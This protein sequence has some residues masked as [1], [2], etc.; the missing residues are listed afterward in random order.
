MA[1]TIHETDGTVDVP[2]NHDRPNGV[3]RTLHFTRYGRVTGENRPAALA[4]HG[5]PGEIPNMAGFLEKTALGRAMFD[6]WDFYLLHQRGAGK[7]LLRDESSLEYVV[8]SQDDYKLPQ[9]LADLEIFR[10]QICASKNGSWD[11]VFGSSWGGNLG[12][13]YLTK[14]PKSVHSF[15]LGSFDASKY[16]TTLTP[17]VMEAAIWDAMHT[18]P[19]LQVLLAKVINLC[20]R[21]AL[22][23]T[24]DGRRVLRQKDL[25]LV[26]F[27]YLAAYDMDALC[28]LLEG[29]VQGEASAL[30]MLTEIFADDELTIGATFPAQATY[31]LE[32][33]DSDL[34]ASRRKPERDCAF[35]DAVA[36]TEA[37]R[38]KV[39]PFGAHDSAE[40]ASESMIIGQSGI[41]FAGRF[42]PMICWRAA[43]MTA[44]RIPTAKFHLLPGGHSPFK[45]A[46]SGMIADVCALAAPT[47]SC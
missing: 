33:V 15:V 39:R 24:A 45:Q 28:S 29:V 1:S 17:Y 4:L 13:S 9:Y 41:M 30:S 22:P 47:L 37:L 19:Q 38:A 46:T 16:S 23:I 35:V 21:G 6:R 31:L 20:Q 27:P 34:I 25:W 10:R 18:L 5:G 32:L 3:K 42:D 36:Y 26:I 14:Y 2:C 40:S 7:S 44:A 12:L 8:Q 43:A 11:L